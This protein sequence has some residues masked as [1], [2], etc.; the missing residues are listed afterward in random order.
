VILEDFPVYSPDYNAVS[1]Q[2]MGHIILII[3][4]FEIINL[5]HGY[6]SHRLL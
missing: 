1:S 6:G 3:L 5:E 2:Q 4:W